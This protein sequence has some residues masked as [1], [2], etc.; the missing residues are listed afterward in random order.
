MGGWERVRLEDGRSIEVNMPVG[1]IS[2]QRIR[3]P[4]QGKQGGDLHLIIEVKPHPF[5]R[6]DGLDIICELPITPVEAIIGGAVDTPTL[7][8]WVT[9]NLP[10]GVC[11]GQR[12]RLGGKGYPG[13][14]GQRGDQL[15]EIRVEIPEVVSQEELELYQK[16]KRIETFKPR[17][18]LPL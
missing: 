2:G 9:M 4:G 11:T 17:S 6:K 1:L 8:G 7:D 15:V 18:G 12:L 3:V 5:F 16:L 10:V 14:E 13:K